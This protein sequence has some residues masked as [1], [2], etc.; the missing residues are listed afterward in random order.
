S[1]DPAAMLPALAREVNRV[2][3]DVPIAETITLITQMEGWMRPVR[4]SATFIGYAAG[5]AM[6]LTA[7]GLYG[8]LAFA[9]SRRRKEI[10]VRIALGATRTSVLGLIVREGMTVVIAGAISGLVLATAGTRFVRHLLYGSAS[11]DWL[12]YLAAA[13]L[14]S[15]VGLVASLLPARRAA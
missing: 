9:V 13:L 6:L 8:S 11:E 7:I 10:G 14:V 3:A 5:L 1:G 15:L 12:F 2:D 4:L